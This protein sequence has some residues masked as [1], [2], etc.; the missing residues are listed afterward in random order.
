MMSPVPTRVAT[1]P[2]FPLALLFACLMFS[3]AVSAAPAPEK[4]PPSFRAVANAD[5]AVMRIEELGGIVRRSGD[6]GFEV[7]FHH[8]GAAIADA[9]LQYLLSLKKV[10]VLRL[11]ETQIT[12]AGLVHVGKLATLKRLY[13]EKTAVTDAGLKHLT[14]LKELEYLNL[15]ACPVGDAGVEGLKDLPKLRQL[16]VAETKVTHAGI[17]RLQAA[18]SVQIVPDPARDRQR[19]QAALDTAKSALATAEAPARPASCTSP[20]NAPCH[21]CP[22]ARSPPWRPACRTAGPRAHGCWHRPNWRSRSLHWT[23]RPYPAD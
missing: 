7:D 9:H 10:V 18:P 17:A 6:D 14:G 8:K 19:A 11:K 13:L 22:N 16:F 20:P 12:D 15:Y 21:S 3:A 4:T 23:N 5:E 2:L 1:C